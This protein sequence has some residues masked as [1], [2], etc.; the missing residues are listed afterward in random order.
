MAARRKRTALK[1]TFAGALRALATALRELG[2]PGMLI[3]GVA[4]IA[5]GVPRT[6]RD[7]DMTLVG[8]KRPLADVLAV[9]G[10]HGL[11]ARIG[12]ALEFAA[13]HQVLL[14]VHQPSKTEVDLSLAWLSFELEAIGRADELELAGVRVPVARAEDLVIYKAIAWRPQ[15]QQDIERLLLLYS[16]QI[17]FER[18]RSIV[19]ELGE[20]LEQPER[21]VE[22]DRLARR[23][24][25]E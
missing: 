21:V 11:L 2:I 8:G 15:D 12:H 9:L 7:V 13:E 16:N 10:K 17:D 14:L 22:L 6:T 19:T 24:R 25:L 20:A 5:R 3:G 4:V 23:V 1:A 18:V